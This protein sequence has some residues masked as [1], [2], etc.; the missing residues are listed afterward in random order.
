MSDDAASHAVGRRVSTACSTRLCLDIPA[1]AFEGECRFWAELTGWPERRSSAE[2][3]NLI[4]PAGSPLRILLQRLGEDDPG[5]ARAH[6]DLACDD[7]PAETRRHQALGAEVVRIAE[8]WTTLRD[9]AGLTYCI[10][11]RD[12]FRD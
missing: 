9:P 2:F 11:S 1:A 12:P 8:H 10:T 6:A 3:V 4:R 5:P 7:I